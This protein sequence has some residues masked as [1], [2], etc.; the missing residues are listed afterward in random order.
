MQQQ[1]LALW[2]GPFH[3]QGCG[4]SLTD[5]A[6]YFGWMAETNTANIKLMRL[7]TLTASWPPL[8][9]VTGFYNVDEADEVE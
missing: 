6:A 3:F 4:V 2:T 7:V 1:K 9:V 5:K 8:R